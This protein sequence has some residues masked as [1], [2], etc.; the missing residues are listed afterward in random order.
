MWAWVVERIRCEGCLHRSKVF[1]AR[2]RQRHT[3]GCRMYRA[4]PNSW[5]N[6]F[7]A[8]L[9]RKVL[10]LKLLSKSGQNVI[11]SWIEQPFLRLDVVNHESAELLPRD[12]PTRDGEIDLQSC[13]ALCTDARQ[14]FLGH[15]IGHGHFDAQRIKKNPS[16]SA[17]HAHD[18]GH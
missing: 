9:E 7:R 12:P 2:V 18:V 13:G 15:V 6:L 16:L 5:A 8:S 4:A 3:G 1:L 14:P 17:R 10:L 11:Q